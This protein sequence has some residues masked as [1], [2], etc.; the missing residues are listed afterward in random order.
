MKNIGLIVI[1]MSL[2]VVMAAC[3]SSEEEGS[4]VDRMLIEHEED[5]PVENA[6]TELKQ[7]SGVQG[8]EVVYATVN[9]K[10]ITGYLARPEGANADAPGLIVIHE[11]WGL[12]DNIRMMTQK[13]AGE[14]YTA[15]AVD[16]YKG[17]VT[18]KPDSAGTYARSVNENEAIDN[19]TQAYNYL[20]DQHEA[21]A[22]GTIGWCFGGGWSLRTALTHPKKIDATVIYYGRLVTDTAQLSKLQMPILGIF[23][24]EDQG[25]PPKKVKEF[26]SALN[27]VGVD[28]SIHIYEGARH[29]FASPSGGRYQ[30]KAAE[31]A[32]KKTITF[33]A[34]H[35]K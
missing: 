25:I 15:L 17:K 10:E 7:A 29:A 20:K 23:G 19:L 34:K 18:E 13:L 27:E 12:N 2:A 30:K 35:L 26:E 8:E 3:G 4:Y 32:W 22:I 21:T 31:D 14:G 1:A 9:G 16:L 24:S 5:K 6:S 28:N 33:L 11:W